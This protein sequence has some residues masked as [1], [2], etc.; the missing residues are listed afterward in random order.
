MKRCILFVQCNQSLYVQS[1]FFGGFFKTCFLILR[2]SIFPDTE[3]LFI[4]GGGKF[5]KK[6]IISGINI[7]N[8]ISTKIVGIK[9]IR[10]EMKI[11][12]ESMEIS[13]DKWKEFAKYCYLGTRYE[14][15]TDDRKLYAKENYLR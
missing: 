13:H 15:L 12:W 3:T 5:K 8:T 7:K 14:E 1:K 4:I 9:D 10:F 6:P 11:L 2:P